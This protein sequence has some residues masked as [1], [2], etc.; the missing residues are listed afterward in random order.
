MKL[1]RNEVGYVTST[2]VDN[3]TFESL[4]TE[5]S[6]AL[7]DLNIPQKDIDELK[8]CPLG[9]R[10]EE[11]VEM[12][13]DWNSHEKECLIMLE[14]IDSS[15]HRLTQITKDG[16]KHQSTSQE[17]ITR[18]F[19]LSNDTNIDINPRKEKDENLFLK[20]EM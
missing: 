2:Q 15:I 18:F 6:Q 16:I 7:V 10:E 11:C 3:A 1:L 9:P 17:Q 8:A 4:W 12:L 5:I 20:E 13:K 14:S 19:N